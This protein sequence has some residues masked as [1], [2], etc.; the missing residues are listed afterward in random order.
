MTSKKLNVLFVSSG[1]H[2]GL[3]HGTRAQMESLVS[4]NVIVDNILIEGKGLK[5]YL[6]NIL[7]LVR[8]VKKSHFDLIHAI[9]GHCGLLCAISLFG[10]KK[11]ISYLGSDIQ[12]SADQETSLL[13]KLIR[14]L[15]YCSSK[16][17]SQ[18]IV[19]SKRMLK[20]LPKEALPKVNVIP[21]GVDFALFKPMGIEEAR[22]KLNLQ[23]DKKYILFLG[24]K[25]LGNKNFELTERACKQVHCDGLEIVNPFPVDHSLIPFYMNAADLLLLTSFSEGSPNIIKEALACNCPIVST[26]VGDVAEHLSNIEGCFVSSFD[27][28]DVAAKITAILKA[29][30]RTDARDNIRHLDKAEIA[31]RILAVYE[32][33]LKSK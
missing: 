22:K 26:D 16:S 17:Y 25:K 11:V 5:G 1:N 31:K 19:K 20:S 29:N 2:G 24:D 14:K 3:H 4:D 18:I 28:D 27:A 12:K 33:A 21:N 7:P 32:T 15:M 10:K 6:K 23:K 30:K 9:G 8:K 13:E